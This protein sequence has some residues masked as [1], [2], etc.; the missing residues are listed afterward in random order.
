MLETREALE[1]LENKITGWLKALVH[2]LPNIVVAALIVVAAWL[3]ARLIRNVSMRLVRRVI[4]H[5]T[6]R[7]FISTAIYLVV[8]M[9]GIFA[10]LSL[11]NL[12]KAVTTVLAGAGIV[13]LA[14]GFAF[15]DIAAN[16]ISGI[17]MAVNRPIR[18]GELIETSDKMGVV[19][20]IDLRTT[21]ITSLQGLQVL[22]P[23]KEI[24]QNIL[25]NYTRNGIRRVD[26]EVGV[27]YGDDLD[28]VE[29]VTIAAIKEIGGLIS[30]R[31]VEL[32]FQG[33]G[34]SSIDLKV[35]FWVEA[36]TQ[37]E[38]LVMQHKA[39][40]AIKAAYDAEDIM[41]PFPI[42][43]LDFGIKGGEKLN[44]ML[45]QNGSSGHVGKDQGAAGRSTIDG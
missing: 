35:R 17:L 38:F 27:S 8:L 6:L 32:F 30:D 40:K 31:D 4:H 21:E 42:R 37:K 23:N 14:I 3:A 2:M 19:K 22:I 39:V 5:E 15:Q 41:I 18:V 7:G 25:T 24:F 16:F 13:G 11:L 26:L 10:A 12:D 45:V 1:L 20:R 36:R 28:K 33:F 43:T 44:T 34:D 9:V 29:K